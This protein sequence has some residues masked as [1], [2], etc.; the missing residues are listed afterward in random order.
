M[1]IAFDNRKKNIKCVSLAPKYARIRYSRKQSAT[2]KVER[3]SYVPEP[4]WGKF[5]QI[6]TTWSDLSISK[7]PSLNVKKCAKKAR[8]KRGIRQAAV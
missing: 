7:L 5:R 1:L 6:W 3:S 4:Y 2:K 8:L